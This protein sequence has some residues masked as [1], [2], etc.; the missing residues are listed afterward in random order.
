VRTVTPAL[1]AEGSTDQ[2]FLPPLIRRVI[3]DLLIH[4]G[5]GGVVPDIE[6]AQWIEL[7]PRPRNQAERI[8]RAAYQAARFDL[9]IIHADADQR[10]WEQARIHKFDPGYQQVQRAKQAGE[11]IC[12]NVIP[13]I[14]VQAIEAWLLADLDTLRSITHI[15]VPVEDLG[16]PLHTRQVESIAKPKDRLKAA[17]DKAW[18]PQTRRRQPAMD[19]IYR[20]L[21]EQINLAR[22]AAVPSYQQFVEDVTSALSI[23]GLV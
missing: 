10:R 22:L 8:V 18:G 1:Y 6:D 9:L 19:S 21:G 4:R 17:L 7:N 11:P 13:L 15:S 12:S 3:E 16:L 23:L 20:P 5:R 14:P 2:R